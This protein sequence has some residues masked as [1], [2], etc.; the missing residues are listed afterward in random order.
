MKTTIE[1][2]DALLK[3]ARQLAVE[4]NTSLKA[5]VEV[6]LRG[7]LDQAAQPS[8]PAFELRGCTFGGSGPQPGIDESDWATIRSMIYKGRGG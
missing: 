7:Y 5:I 4:R 3:Q 8:R 2:N 6:A 1:I